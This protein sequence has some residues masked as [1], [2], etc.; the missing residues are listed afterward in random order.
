MIK[1]VVLV[2]T[3]V[4]MFSNI[5]FSQEET[6]TLPKQTKRGT[7]SR[8]VPGKV[9]ADKN[10]DGKP[11]YAEYF[12][13]GVVEH[14]EADTDYDG[15]MDE[16]TYFDSNGKPLKTERDTNKHGKADTWVHYDENQRPQ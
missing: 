2:L 14:R 16:W 11:D 4:L 6:N 12:Q 7:E 10:Y 15:V 9:E 13:N 8:V 1:Y 3:L 5:G